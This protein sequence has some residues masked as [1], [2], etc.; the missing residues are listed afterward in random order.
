M[1][2]KWRA[3]QEPMVSQVGNNNYY[4]GSYKSVSMVSGL[5]QQIQVKFEVW[6]PYSVFFFLM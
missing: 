3:L 2:Q 6:D 1:L 5:T 4:Q